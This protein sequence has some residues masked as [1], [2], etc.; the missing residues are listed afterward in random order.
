MGSP[1]IASTDALEVWR[2]RILS[3]VIWTFLGMTTVAAIAGM[4]VAVS[5]GL[6][7]IV[8]FDA[9]AWLTG[10]AL[11]LC[12]E[13]FYRFKSVSLIVIIYVVGCYFTYR[14]GPLAAGP[15]WL[16]AGPMLAGA[17]FGRRAALGALG[18][19][20]G[21]IVVI[22]AL[23]AR[24]SLDWSDEFAFERWVVFGGSLVAL[25]GSL[26]VAIGVLLD[27]VAQANRER[28][29]A[30]EARERLEH[31]L[32]HSQKMEAVGRL[33]GGIAH[34][35]NNLLIAISGFTELAV[36]SLEEAPSALADL[37]EV[38]HA[39]SKGKGLT[40]QLLTFSRKN[41]SAPRNIDL[42]SYIKTANRLIEQL[43]GEDIQVHNKLCTETCTAAIDPD[44]FS[45][46][47]VNA[48]LNSKDAMQDG[49]DLTIETARVQI[50]PTS[51]GVRGLEMAHGDYVVVSVTDTGTGVTD[52]TLEQIFEPFF[53]TKAVGAGTGLGL[54]TCWAIVNQAGGYVNM[55][56]E[57]GH[58]AT[59]EIYLPFLLA[60]VTEP[61]ENSSPVPASYGGG[62]I[63]FVEDDEQ[64]RKVLSRSLRSKGYRV[65]E[66]GHAEDA[67]GLIADSP[68][69]IDLLITDVMMP[70]R[71]GR[72]LATMVADLK[73]GIA[74]IYISGYSDDVLTQKGVLEPGVTL[75]K[76]PFHL[77]DL[78]QRVQSLLNSVA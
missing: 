14:F 2:S 19:L 55:L 10:L 59:L 58:G 22:G 33:A 11:A 52:A 57:Q 43:S 24:G 39:V 23:A 60:K 70:G 1:D 6:W 54:S 8:V 66:A 72:E 65:L 71:N 38:Q 12:P 20:L 32:R 29:N 7:S 48:T 49:G 5:N 46:I 42:N 25:S 67:L 28:E 50:G 4:S 17:L 21:I 63:L 53:S 73:P 36:E 9:V 61:V 78:T 41:A 62:T 51:A 31:Q 16:F 30:I 35:F 37:A 3:A 44:S 47:L 64:V 75:L 40:E 76:K 27:G 45:Q 15:L 68:G 13:R 74:V 26:S 18:G 77:E 69:S 56:S 34:D